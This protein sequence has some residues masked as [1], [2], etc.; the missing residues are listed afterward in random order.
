VNSDN[1]I[2]PQVPQV[3]RVLQVSHPLAPFEGRADNSDL[4]ASA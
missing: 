3:P 4:N 1:S 2:K